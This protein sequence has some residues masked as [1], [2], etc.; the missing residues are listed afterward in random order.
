MKIEYSRTGG[1]AAPA[2]RQKLEID[3]DDLTPD[4]ARDLL[5]LVKHA[6][7]SRVNPD[8]HS[9]RSRDAFRY[10]VTITDGDV[11]H[12]VTASDAEMPE[13]LVPLIDWLSD[14]AANKT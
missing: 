10:R 13:A 11:T 2:L 5:G 9:D 1:F 3:T 4:D 8:P 12:T 6:Q 14:R 7:R